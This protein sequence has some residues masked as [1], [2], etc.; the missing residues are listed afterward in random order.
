MLT[1]R[2]LMSRICDIDHYA[3]GN[4]EALRMFIIGFSDKP[5][6]MAKKVDGFSAILWPKYTVWGNFKGAPLKGL[7]PNLGCQCPHPHNLV[8]NC[9]IKLFQTKLMN[10]M[11]SFYSCRKCTGIIMEMVCD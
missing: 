1:L 3:L 2:G 6:K 7:Q 5:M 4:D 9:C 10:V 11:T 8:C